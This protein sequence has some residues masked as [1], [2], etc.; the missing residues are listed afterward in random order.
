MTKKDY[1]ILAEAIRNASINEHSKK[2]ISI[3]IAEALKKD[4]PAFK[5]SLFFSTCGISNIICTD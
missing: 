5:G 1:Q 2:I 3:E 4:N